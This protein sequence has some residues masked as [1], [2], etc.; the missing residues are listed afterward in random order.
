VDVTRI[1]HFKGFDEFW[2]IPADADS[3]AEGEWREAPGYD[4]F[5]TVRE[6]LGDLPFVVED[7]G[8]IDPS[9][10]SLRDEFSF[11]GMRVPHY[12]D[13]CS[14]DSRDKPSNYPENCVAY[15]ATHDTDTSVGYYR[16]IDDRQRDC[17]HYALN[18]D[19]S[20]FHW[21]LVDAVWNSNAVLAM[22]TMQDLLGLDSHARFNTPGTAEGNWSWRVT[23]EGLDDDVA[24]RLAT[25][26][27][28]HVRN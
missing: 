19:G 20:E 3:A 2:A 21:T 4:F 11:P 15:T 1:D 16:S 10:V 8:F 24:A 17:L 18:A 5:R 28:I 7:L 6:E 12:A 27:D 23:R 25:L 26:T 22:T 9:L 13:W 14:A